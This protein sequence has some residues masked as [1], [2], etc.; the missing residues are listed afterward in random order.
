VDRT[1]T[2]EVVLVIVWRGGEKDSRLHLR[3]GTGVYQL[4]GI[5]AGMKKLHLCVLQ[6]NQY[7]AFHYEP[8]RST[9]GYPTLKLRI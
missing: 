6:A 8:L 1:F 3:Q 9:W 2:N 7:G 5:H 4:Q